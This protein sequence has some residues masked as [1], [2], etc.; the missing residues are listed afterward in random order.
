MV[1]GGREVDNET[2]VDIIFFWFYAHEALFVWRTLSACEF[3]IA[4]NTLRSAKKIDSVHTSEVLKRNW[5]FNF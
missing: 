3:E 5:N 1:E 2:C 4:V